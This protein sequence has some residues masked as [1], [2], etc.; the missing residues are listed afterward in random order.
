M[1]DDGPRRRLG[2]VRL[3]FFTILTPIAFLSLVEGGARLLESE[4]IP[5]EARSPC[6]FQ[7]VEQDPRFRELSGLSDTGLKVDPSWA[8]NDHQVVHVPKPD[9]EFRIVMLGGSALG[10]WGLPPQAQLSGVVQRLLGQANPGKRVRVV[11][12]GKTGWASPQLAWTFGKAAGRLDPDLVVTVMGNNERM[13]LANAIALNDFQHERLL[14]RRDALRRSA[15]LRRL[16][17]K[18]DVHLDLP[19]PPMPQRWDLPMHDDITAYAMA[20]LKRTVRRL[21]KDAD[22]PM[23][24]A[25][26]PVN[27]RYHRGT[28]EWWFV[29]EDRMDA[30]PYRTAHWAWYYDAPEAGLAAVAALDE[31]PADLLQ[32]WFLK[33]LGRDDEAAAAFDAALAGIGPDPGEAGARMMAAWAT[34][35]RF[36]ADAAKALVVPW[37]D[38]LRA[39]SIEGQLP[40]D[41]PDLLWYAGDEEAA[42]PLYEECLLHRFYYRAD[43]ETNAGLRAAADAAGAEFVD[44][45]AAVR[46]ASPH[47]VPAFEW[48]YDYC[49]YTPRGNVLAGTVL[50]RALAPYLDV[51]PSALPTPDEALA[52]YDALRNGSLLDRLEI[53]EWTGVAWDVTLL[54]Q[55]RVDLQQD[56]RTGD[57]ESWTAHAFHGNRD[58]ST[59]ALSSLD[60]TRL[61]LH[62]YVRALRQEPGAEVVRRNLELLLRSEAGRAFLSGEQGD[63]ETTR[64]LREIAAGLEPAG[65]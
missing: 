21:A 5:I 57:E 14:A 25:S 61:A 62:S 48:F 43:A 32:G 33:R 64:M 12:L 27:H 53:E 20:R 54:T 39:V 4:P 35:G 9:D 17:P 47:G 6:H 36:G 24:V 23:V 28:K 65:L 3:A 58:A 51:D 18:P 34:Q 19:S 50:A 55:L 49:H 63:D 59:A 2:P 37:I 10:G 22:A 56:R 60:A 52:R 26:V 42:A 45:D 16:E 44:L 40:C 31:A 11:N 30:E 1:A 41:V 7:Q 46:A 29:G 8:D 13:D 15:L 38:D